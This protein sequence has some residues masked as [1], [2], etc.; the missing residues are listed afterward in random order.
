MNLKRKSPVPFYVV[1]CIGA[2]VIGDVYIAAKTTVAPSTQ[3]QASIKPGGSVQ[4]SLGA[5]TTPLPSASVPAPRV[6]TSTASLPPS[7]SMCGV[8]VDTSDWQTYRNQRF[9]FEV[10]Y[11][12][13]WRTYTRGEGDYVST[14]GDESR[15]AISASLPEDG[16]FVEI[17]ALGSNGLAQR[18]RSATSVAAYVTVWQQLSTSMVPADHVC[19]IG[20]DSHWFQVCSNAGQC[21]LRVFFGHDDK[22]FQ[23]DKP[24]SV[25]LGAFAKILSTWK[26]NSAR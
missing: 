18:L 9:G 6:A 16:I 10:K 26:F 24:T 11:P 17:R 19:A 23:I 3:V 13:A 22:V 21:F 5:I 7:L 2:I 15:F 1:L 8:S 14:F 25:D 20:T 4:T 12:K